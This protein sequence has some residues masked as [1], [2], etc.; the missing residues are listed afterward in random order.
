VLSDASDLIITLKQFGAFGILVAFLI[1]KDF[2]ADAA[3]GRFEE[4]HRTD[5]QLADEKRMN[6]DRER[7]DTDKILASNL[8]SLTAAIQTM[9]RR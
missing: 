3:R 4:K 8:A 5:K 2:R 1:W 6:Y 7:L 9:V